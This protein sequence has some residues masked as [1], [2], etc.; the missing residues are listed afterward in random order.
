VFGSSLQLISF[1]AY[2]LS[3]NCDKSAMTTRQEFKLSRVIQQLITSQILSRWLESFLGV[4]NG[5]I[6]V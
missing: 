2:N 5:L 6:N 4:A 1:F 3:T